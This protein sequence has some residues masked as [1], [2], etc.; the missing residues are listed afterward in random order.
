VWALGF[1]FLLA[2][3]QLMLYLLN[4]FGMVRIGS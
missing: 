4:R 2:F 3:A 1:L